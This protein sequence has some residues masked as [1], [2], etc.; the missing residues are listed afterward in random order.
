MTILGIGDKS[1]Q[2][3]ERFANEAKIWPSA[4]DEHINEMSW[5]SE[6]RWTKLFI[7]PL[8]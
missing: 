6:K 2:I 8:R 3:Y 1:A 4:Q 7:D 5:S